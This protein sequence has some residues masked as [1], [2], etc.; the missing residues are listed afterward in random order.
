MLTTLNEVNIMWSF[1]ANIKFDVNLILH[2]YYNI[3]M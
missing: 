3:K 1:N 2:I